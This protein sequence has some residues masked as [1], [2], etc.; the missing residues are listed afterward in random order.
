MYKNFFNEITDKRLIVGWNK[1]P[2]ENKQHLI[3]KL[4]E[5][6]YQTALRGE[7]ISMSRFQ[8]ITLASVSV[9]F[10]AIKIVTEEKKYS[11][12]NTN[13]IKLALSLRTDNSSKLYPYWKGLHF[14]NI[15]YSE[16]YDIYTQSIAWITHLILEPQWEAYLEPS[17]FGFRSYYSKKD[18]IL[19]LLKQIQKNKFHYIIS[20]YLKF[21]LDQK[22]SKILAKKL[23]NSKYIA[24]FLNRY[25]YAKIEVVNLTYLTTLKTSKVSIEGLLLN[26]LTYGLTYHLMEN[27]LLQKIDNPQNNLSNSIYY[28][29]FGDCFCALCHS[30]IVSK[31]LLQILERNFTSLALNPSQDLSYL[32]PEF[33]FLGFLFK[34]K[35]NSIDILPD[36]NSQKALIYKIRKVLY[37]KDF[38]GRTRALTHLTLEKAIYKINPILLSWSCCHEIC[39]QNKYFR[40]IDQIIDNTLYR[41]QIKKY[42][43]NTISSWKKQCIKYIKNR[44]RITEGKAL[45]KL[46]YLESLK[47]KTYSALFYHRSIYD[48][49]H[50]YWFRREKNLKK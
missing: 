11:I 47:Q 16:F 30:S 50:S 40:S 35:A 8:K 10:V 18:A 39:T 7:I 28:I 27:R 1:I 5:Q 21:K 42:K 22:Q 4:Q 12:N 49:D 2:W 23:H 15:S 36:I 25:L 46:L 29:N 20:G 44:K 26:I 38:I 32:K 19:A 14:N 33:R 34:I 48:Q 6:I 43:R 31:W 41:W 13:K 45:L 37:K 17:I 24:N 9:K 3:Q